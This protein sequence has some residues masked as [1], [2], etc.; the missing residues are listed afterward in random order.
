M[1]KYVKNLLQAELEKKIENEAIRD[2][3]V[4]NT[5]GL[6]GNSGNRLRSELKKKGIKLFVV[7]NALFKV[8]LKSSKME[9]AAGLFEG[10][11]AVAYGGD[12]I[13]DVARELIDWKKKL[14]VLAVKGAYLDGNS[15]DAKM[16]EQLSKMPTRGELQGQIVTLIT[17]P[18]RKVASAILGAGSRVSG[19]L[20][21]IAEKAEK[22]AA[23]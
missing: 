20:K 13:V 14:P 8:A 19:C 23:A 4:V 12:S 22:Q 3:M 16:A 21:T 6:D 1:S 11:C 5:I 9:A 2:F 17:S 18:A 10:T 15:L 7:K